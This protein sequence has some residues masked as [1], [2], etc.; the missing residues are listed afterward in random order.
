MQFPMVCPLNLKGGLDG[1]PAELNKVKL[2]RNNDDLPTAT[3]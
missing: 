1:E 3:S 2:K